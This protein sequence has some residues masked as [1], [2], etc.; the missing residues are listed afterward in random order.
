MQALAEL[1]YPGKLQR[2]LL[3][4]EREVLTPLC[5]LSG[6]VF[7]SLLGLAAAPCNMLERE[8]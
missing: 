8:L 3:T 7:K 2:L 6:D 4:P 1:E 5:L